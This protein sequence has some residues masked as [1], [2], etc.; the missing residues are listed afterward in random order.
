[1]TMRQGEDRIREGQQ[2]GKKRAEETVD[3]RRYKEE[4]ALLKGD[5]VMRRDKGRSRKETRQRRQG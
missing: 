4:R 5:K 1:M 3:K 2:K